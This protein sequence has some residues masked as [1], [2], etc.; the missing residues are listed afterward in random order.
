MLRIFNFLLFII[1]S[2]STSQ[3]QE[4]SF[5]KASEVASLVGY[6]NRLALFLISFW[7]ICDLPR[8]SMAKWSR[9]LRLIFL[10]APSIL[11][12][13]SRWDLV[14][15]DDVWR[16]CTDYFPSLSSFPMLEGRDPHWRREPQSFKVHVPS[17]II[18]GL[19]VIRPFHGGSCQCL[20][21]KS[22]ETGTTFPVSNCLL[23]G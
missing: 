7:G 3:T 21:P 23:K 10:K 17:Q 11:L 18:T 20:G 16:Y 14:V 15:I 19:W 4:G 8:S 13:V 12:K 9:Y 1:T 2:I 6:P 5:K 22:A